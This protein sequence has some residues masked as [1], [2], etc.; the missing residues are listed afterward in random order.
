MPAIT[1]D[2]IRTLAAIRSDAP[3]VTTCY[4]DVD[5]SRYVRPADYERVLDQL[6]RRVRGNGVSDTVERDLR[7]IEDAVKSGFDRS[8]VRGVALFASD[9]LDLWQVIELPVPVRSELVVNTAPAVGQLE[10]VVQQ[11]TSI[12]VLAVDRQHARIFVY[13]LG[14]LLEKAET[15]SEGARDYDTTGEHDRGGVHD[16]RDELH[17]QH[18][19]TAAALA[20]SVHQ[21]HPF[22]HVVIAASDKVVTQLERDLHPYLRERLHRRL[23][24]EPSAS[25]A[26]IRA[27]VLAAAT[28]IEI[29]REAQLVDE[30]RAA[31][32]AKGRGVAGIS[33][34]LA[35]LSEQRVERLLVSDGY[36]ES[37]WHCLSCGRLAM[38]GRLCDCGAEMEHL[39]DV[40]EH[41][42]DEA[43]AQSC[44]VDVC[45]DN[46][47]LDVM[48]RIGALLRY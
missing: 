20:W 35:A 47:D 31:V 7:R 11:A 5:G 27:A 40:V 18:V 28:R 45:I 32:A 46:A 9:E 3:A 44:R 2:Q 16:H 30:L 42:V 6:V 13:R 34:V 12:G 10:A 1:E 41:A 37:G 43:L 19:R 14:E 17:H 39:D 15:D 4:L 25:D 21:R 48:G 29:E 38:V 36:A 33:P 26:E 23:G 22:D 24:V 8:R